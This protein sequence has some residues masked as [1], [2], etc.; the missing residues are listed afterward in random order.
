M[1]RMVSTVC[2]VALAFSATAFGLP[3]AND[4][5]ETVSFMQLILGGQVVST[6][7]ECGSF[8][9]E[10]EV[11]EHQ[12]ANPNG[13]QVTQKIPG[14]LRYTNILCT[15]GLSSDTAFSDWRRQ[16]ELGNVSAARTNGSLVFMTNT[17]QEVVRYN[18]TNA[19]PSKL[20]IN[21]EGAASSSPVTEEI[22]FVI[23]SL[24]RQ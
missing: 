18:F 2:F 7:R 14:R 6:L 19:W 8:G 5:P 10:S 16:V 23:E 9:S 11:I 4:P 24:T 15:R 22:E 1:W 17:A 13:S 3:P 21:W 12:V 20:M